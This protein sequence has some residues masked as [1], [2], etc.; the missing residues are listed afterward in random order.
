MN[1]LIVL[2]AGVLALVGF[3][4][5]G[6]Y[7]SI[8]TM[9]TALWP[10]LILFGLTAAG[11]VALLL[12]FET[13]SKWISNHMTRFGMIGTLLGMV[14][15]LSGLQ[16]SGTDIAGMATELVHHT[17]FAFVS[18]LAGVMGNIWLNLNLRIKGHEA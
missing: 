16:F 10:A 18:T 11:V 5:I 1:K 17:A 7:V 3:L 8:A 4:W 14:G 12:G 15:G 9:G 13:D 2:N 6:G